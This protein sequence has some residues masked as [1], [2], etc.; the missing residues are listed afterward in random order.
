ML[1]TA[2]VWLGALARW[3]SDERVQSDLYRIR[4]FGHDDRLMEI[5]CSIE[6]F[7][8]VRGGCRV[9]WGSTLIHRL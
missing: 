2:G 1:R 6:N 8:S 5:F 7:S 9:D 3:R 4:L